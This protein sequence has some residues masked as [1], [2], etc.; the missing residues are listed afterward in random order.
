MLQEI[1][2]KF[3]ASPALEASASESNL[4]AA[5]E[6]ARELGCEPLSTGSRV[7]ALGNDAFEAIVVV[8]AELTPLDVADKNG[9]A[10]RCVRTLVIGEPIPFATPAVIEAPKPSRNRVSPLHS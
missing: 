7:A 9:V 4:H 10:I 8:D 6:W 5:R 1:V 2:I 3:T